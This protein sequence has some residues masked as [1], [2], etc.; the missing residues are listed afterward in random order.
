MARINTTFDLSPDEYMSGDWAT[1]QDTRNF[2]Y[3]IMICQAFQDKVK[4]YYK[5]GGTTEA[6]SQRLDEIRQAL[7]EIGFQDGESIYTIAP[8][9]D[10]E[11]VP[12]CGT[13][14]KYVNGA[15]VRS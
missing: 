4:E 3:L 1:S 2:A 15:C 14:E 10:V 7:I 13:N 11:G 12:S 9:R 8:S 6:R 5:A